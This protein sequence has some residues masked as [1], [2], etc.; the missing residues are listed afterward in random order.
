MMKSARSECDMWHV[1]YGFPCP[2]FSM[3][4]KRN[5]YSGITIGLGTK[6]YGFIQN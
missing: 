3:I 6:I 2:S 5:L 4:I 1:I